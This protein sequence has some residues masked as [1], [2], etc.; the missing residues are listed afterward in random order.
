MILLA[1]VIDEHL[2]LSGILER[3]LAI[4][5]V[6]WCWSSPFESVEVLRFSTSALPKPSLF[7]HNISARFACE[8]FSFH[9]RKMSEGVSNSPDCSKV[10]RVKSCYFSVT[11][12]FVIK[13][14]RLCR[15]HWTSSLTS[16]RFRRSRYERSK[17]FSEQGASK[18][19]CKQNYQARVVE[20]QNTRSGRR[21][22]SLISY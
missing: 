11:S 13:L 12:K 20:N 3:L 7:W 5:P 1:L 19:F 10:K 16:S 18:H 14:T 21:G 15:S 22:V 17:M 2:T 4:P 9:V 6:K 8:N